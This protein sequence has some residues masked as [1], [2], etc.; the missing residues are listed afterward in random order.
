MCRIHQEREPDHDLKGKQTT[1]HPQT[2]RPQGEKRCHSARSRHFYKTPT[3][4]ANQ[5]TGRKNAPRLSDTDPGKAR[6]WLVLGS[7]AQGEKTHKN[8][9]STEGTRPNH[10]T[11]WG[12]LLGVSWPVRG[13]P[14]GL[15]GGYGQVPPPAADQSK[16]RA[17][18]AQV[19]AA[20]CRQQTR[21]ENNHGP[22]LPRRVSH[23][24]VSECRGRRGGSAG[25]R[26]PPCPARGPRPLQIPHWPCSGRGCWGRV[27][28]AR[29]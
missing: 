16:P 12:P 17:A 24:A 14:E 20:I 29:T 21:Q 2:L 23:T 11:A 9:S 5:E 19:D 6:C 3:M 8:C 22:P 25:P 10:G 7:A 1:G 26:G 4:P 13:A 15:P 28:C 27:Q 18:D